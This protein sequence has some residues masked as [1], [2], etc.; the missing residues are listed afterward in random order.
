[1]RG[2]NF[3]QKWESNE[4]EIL[5]ANYGNVPRQE[6]MR[7]LPNRT[8]RTIME[9]A[10]RVG[11]NGNCN[12]GRNDFTRNGDITTVFLEKRDG[13]VM[14]CFI[15]TVDSDR[16]IGAG[17]WRA[18]YK[19]KNN[20]FY[21][22]CNINTG[23]G[24][25][26]VYMHR[27]I[28]DCPDR[29]L[30]DHIDG[31]TLNNLRSNLRVVTKSE[32]GHNPVQ[33]ARAKSGVRNLYWNPSLSLWVVKASFNKKTTCRYFKTKEAAESEIAAIINPAT[34]AS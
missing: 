17:K 33:P 13:S 2:S 20:T 23:T 29:L 30:V 16:I 21:A 24:K 3:G 10:R 19:K 6:L 12:T 11:V 8:W 4:I 9:R 7:L 22:R 5:S 14:E 27:L 1:M 31:S 32:N 26:Y 28:M 15:S 18:D 25:T 34:R